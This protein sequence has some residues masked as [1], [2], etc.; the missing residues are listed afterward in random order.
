LKVRRR[1]ERCHR[2]HKILNLR[3][4]ENLTIRSH[5]L[6]YMVC[7]AREP[8]LYNECIRR[9]HH[10]DFKIIG[11]AQL[12]KPKL[13][14]RDVVRKQRLILISDCRIRVNNRISAKPT[15]HYICVITR[16]TNE[17]I[18]AASSL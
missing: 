17:R 5:K 18:S 4:Q 11:A 1:R 9:P 12:T 15:R 6:L 10:A 2:I 7:T 8:I 3:I 13:I 14:T 16:T